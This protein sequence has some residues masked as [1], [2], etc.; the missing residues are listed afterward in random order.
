MITVWA[1]PGD[2]FSTSCS[3][4]ETRLLVYKLSPIPIGSQ[5][6]TEH[7]SSQAVKSDA[8][9]TLRCGALNPTFTQWL[10]AQPDGPPQLLDASLDDRI[11]VTTVSGGSELRISK[12]HAMDHAG[13]YSC[14]FGL[15][16]GTGVHTC[17]ANVSHASE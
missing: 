12:F 7:P 11:T 4:K 6:I 15:G 14:L 5:Y 16:G 1:C 13:L 3:V 10:K 8:N 9:V 17:P 2:G